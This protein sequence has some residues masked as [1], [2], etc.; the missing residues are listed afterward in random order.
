M[1]TP[2]NITAVHFETTDEQRAQRDVNALRER[3]HREHE[4]NTR[5]KAKC[6]A[7][8]AL[9]DGYAHQLEA[10]QIFITSV[11]VKLHE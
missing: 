4:E 11:R 6:A 10:Q 5:L 7:L 2:L 3:L 1:K 8:Q 9:V